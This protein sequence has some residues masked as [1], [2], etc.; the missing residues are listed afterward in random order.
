M[1]YGYDRLGRLIRVE[2]PRNVDVPREDFV[3]H[4]GGAVSSHEVVRRAERRNERDQYEYNPQGQLIAES[5]AGLGRTQYGYDD[6]GRRHHVIHP[7]GTESLYTF[8]DLNRIVTIRGSHQPPVDLAY[9][10]N[11]QRTVTPGNPASPGNSVPE[12]SG[13]GNA[14][15]AKDAA[16]RSQP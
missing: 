6:R 10:E 14:A 8:D 11:G 2:R 4:A 1:R 13:A 12:S 15:L 5:I 7:D 16:I 9:D 3:Y